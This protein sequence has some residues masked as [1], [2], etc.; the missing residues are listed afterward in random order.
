MRS[1]LSKHYHLPKRT[2]IESKPIHS[3]HRD[4]GIMIVRL[5]EILLA[6]G[7]LYHKGQGGMVR[8]LI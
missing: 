1:V 6:I 4:V 2:A 5:V 3:P 7:P 8:Q